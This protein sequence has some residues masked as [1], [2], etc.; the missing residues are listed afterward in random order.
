M[1]LM[2]VHNYFV[3]VLGVVERT[4]KEQQMLRRQPIDLSFGMRQGMAVLD[5][6][7]IVAAA[8]GK[9]DVVVGTWHVEIDGC[10]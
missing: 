1:D 6:E 4:G 2:V 10:K 5:M 8:A 3:E 7:M 9:L